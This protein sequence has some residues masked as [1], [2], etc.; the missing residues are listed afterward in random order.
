MSVG[1]LMCGLKAVEK[2]TEIE[3]KSVGPTLGQK[4]FSKVVLNFFKQLTFWPK[5]CNFNKN[6]VFIEKPGCGPI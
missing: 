4:K 3:T 2:S 1:M 6:A 5:I